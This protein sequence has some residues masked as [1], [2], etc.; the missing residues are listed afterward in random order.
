ML[1]P[2]VCKEKSHLLAHD[3]AIRCG[4]SEQSIATVSSVFFDVE[5][6][7]SDGVMARGCEGG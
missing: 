2:Y 7:R 1:N 5:K 4:V 6:K 3:S